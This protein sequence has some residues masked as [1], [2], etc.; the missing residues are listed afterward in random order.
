MSNTEN[1]IEDKN[2][3]A[4]CGGA[5][6][7][8]SGC[9][10]LVSD[11]PSFTYPDIKAKIDEGNISIK[12]V[13]YK[14]SIND[15]LKKILVL[16]A[17]SI[18]KGIVDLFS[19]SS[20]CKMLTAKGCSYSLEDRPSLGAILKPAQNM[21]CA[22]SEKIQLENL[23]GWIKHQY[24]LEKLVKTYT[25]KHV[26]IVYREQFIKEC[27]N[28]LAKIKLLRGNINK[29]TIADQEILDTINS[30]SEEM[31]YELKD[32]NKIAEE[33]ISNILSKHQ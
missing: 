29:L 7:K 28:V 8:K 21:H 4:K 33:T 1:K 6:C 17:R 14:K 25:G 11:F 15:K 5:C 18:D 27:A 2:I 12:A 16:K 13:L 30:M 32:A 10:Y 23:Q 20:Q 31:Y 9:G 3:C 26:D 24:V 22:L 19:A